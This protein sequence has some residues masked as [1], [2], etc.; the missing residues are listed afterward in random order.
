MATLSAKRWL[1]FAALALAGGTLALGAAPAAAA[2]S[3][4]MDTTTRADAASAAGVS[5]AVVAALASAVTVPGARVESRLGRPSERV[6]RH[7]ARR[8][9]RR[10]RATLD[11]SGR[12]AVK[13]IGKRGRGDACE[14]WTWAK[15]KVW[16][17]VPV[18]QRAVAAGQPLAPAVT[19][20]ERG[21]RAGH[22]PA[23][24][25]PGAVANRWLPAGRMIEAGQ[26]RAA[27]PTPGKPIKIV[28]KSGSLVIEQDGSVV[29]CVRDRACAV[30]P[31][32][33][34]LEGRHRRR[35]LAGGNAMKLDQELCTSFVAARSRALGL[36]SLAALAALLLVPACGPAHT[37][38]YKQKK[39][40]YELENKDDGKAG[41]LS[42]G[43]LWRDGRPASMLFTD[44]RALH[45]NDLVVI[46]IEE[47]ANA[48]RS[49]DTNMDRSS[50][51]AA[52]I[53][54]FLGLLKKLEYQLAPIPA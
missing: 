22:V 28:I 33:R 5:P 3:D 23:Q 19:Y 47:I 39:R 8:H 15:V 53:D 13:L 38:A 2:A 46:N 17:R 25:A 51:S 20:T 29:P 52:K 50:S 40:A 31:S 43:S 35:T 18:T 7:P 32:G 6:V 1:G 49:T 16:A 4:T 11:G 42:E 44:A 54:A 9:P 27:G 10:G 12:I 34:R 37:G 41:A 26:L 21:I 24:I 48:S 45:A 36:A 30:L 14:V